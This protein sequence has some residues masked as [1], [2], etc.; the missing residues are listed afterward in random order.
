MN[1]FI[2]GLYNQSSAL[3]TFTNVFNNLVVASMKCSQFWKSKSCSNNLLQ[4]PFCAWKS[5]WMACDPE[6]TFRQPPFLGSSILC[7]FSALSVVSCGT[8]PYVLLAI[9]IMIKLT[10]E[11]RWICSSVSLNSDGWLFKIGLKKSC[12]WI[13]SHHCK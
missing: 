12:D 7:Q 6:N 3:C 9:A 13:Q 1:C 10:K 4:R 11:T 5:Y 8:L 2:Q